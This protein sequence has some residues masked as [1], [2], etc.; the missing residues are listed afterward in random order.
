MNALE[1]VYEQIETFSREAFLPNRILENSKSLRETFVR[2]QYFF[3]ETAG[4][5]AFMDDDKSR[6][7]AQQC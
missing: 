1:K 6:K 2:Y 4:L 7:A 3:E 5:Q